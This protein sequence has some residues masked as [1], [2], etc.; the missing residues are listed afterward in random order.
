[1]SHA[2]ALALLDCFGPVKLVGMS[3][4]SFSVSEPLLAA[5]LQ[6]FAPELEGKQAKLDSDPHFWMPLTLSAPAYATGMANKGVPAD[7]TQ[8]H[9]LRMTRFKAAFL[10]AHP[11]P[12][13]FG[14]IDAGAASC[15]WDFGQL[16][17]YRQNCLSVAAEGPEPDA[18]RTFLRIN[19]RRA[20]GAV[21][22]DVDASSV[23]LG[24]TLRRGTVRGSVCVGGAIGDLDVADSLLINVTARRVKA[25][26]CVLYN[27]I[28]DSEEGIDLPDGTVRADIVTGQDAKLVILSTLDTDGGVAWKEKLPGN[29]LSFEGVYNLNAAV[30]VIA[31]QEAARAWA[32]R[33][34]AAVAP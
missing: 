17:L 8:A 27:V 9:Y 31:A 4:G 34:A 21:T 6:E 11:G 33:V 16:K 10:A 13:M 30:D 5:F 23:C 14:C 19:H 2:T 20:G 25:R 7:V 22:A 3:L 1:V 28:D 26:G 32:A 15:F 18:L 29:P 12:G 24:S